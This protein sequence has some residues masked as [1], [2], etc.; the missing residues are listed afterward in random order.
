MYVIDRDNLIE[1]KKLY[2]KYS[3]T[4]KRIKKFEIY[5]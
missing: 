4:L 2:R 1:K 5:V 3:K